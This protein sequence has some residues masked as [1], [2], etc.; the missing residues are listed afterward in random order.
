MS[1]LRLERQ[2]MEILSIAPPVTR[3]TRAEIEAR[4]RTAKPIPS[5]HRIND[6]LLGLLEGEEHYTSQISGVIRRD[7]SLSSRMLHLAN[8]VYFGLANPIQ[9]IEEAVLYLGMQEMRQFALLTPI[10]EEFQKLSNDLPFTWREFWQ[11]CIATAILS[12]D[13]V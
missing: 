9:T 4:L 11:H 5:L 7:P 3:L 6:S 12:R 13:I 2:N 8:S 1:L 10:V